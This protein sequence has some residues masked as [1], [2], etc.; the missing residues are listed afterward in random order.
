MQGLG[1]RV[2]LWSME[3]AVNQ[4]K[5]VPVL[6]QISTMSPDEWE[7]FIEEWMTVQEDAY[8]DIEK[9]GGAG[10]K[11]RDVVGYVDDPVG[12]QNYIWDNFQ[13]KHYA[14]SLAPSKVWVEIAKICYYAFVGEFP[15]PRKYYFVAPRGVGTKLS[16]FLKKPETLKSELYANWEKYCKTKITE[17]KEV[18]LSEDLKKYIDG[19]D[20]AVFDKISTIKIIQEHRE[21]PFHVVRFGV[22]LP[23]RPKIQ[24]VSEEIGGDEVTYIGKLI[25]AY[26]SHAS[27]KIESLDDVKLYP[28]YDRHLRRSREEFFHAEALKGFSR[29]TLPPGEY[30]DIQGQLLNGVSDILDSECP[31]G[32]DKVKSVVSEARKLQLPVTPLSSCIT[33]YDR[34]G[35]CHQ[36]A[37]DDFLSWCDDE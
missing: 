32:F 12:R 9:L 27:E 22:P 14:E 36:L 13:C 16:G 4:A 30:E 5:G 31:N 24:A 21:T 10:D 34:G 6:N 25:S 11:G 29:D 8:F 23:E 35:I 19:L 33:T 18:P 20:F 28:I 2:G 15:F 1:H 3:G 26:R 37:N 17:I 7:E